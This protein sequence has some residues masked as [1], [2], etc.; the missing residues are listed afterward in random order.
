MFRK[1][2]CLSH[3]NYSDVLTGAKLKKERTQ[4]LVNTKK[5]IKKPEYDLE[6]DDQEVL[7]DQNYVEVLGRDIQ[8][9]LVVGVGET[10]L[11]FLLVAE[12]A[13]Q[14]T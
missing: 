2:L 12:I 8:G 5:I 13:L 14:D 6:E 1:N 9:I 11:K 4:L 7:K 3:C 10:T